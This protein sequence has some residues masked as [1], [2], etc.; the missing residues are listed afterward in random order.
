[1]TN[2]TSIPK[3][4]VNIQ[5]PINAALVDITK[6]SKRYIMQVVASHSK[7]YIYMPVLP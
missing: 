7:P 2:S 1:M 3:A 4:M 5:A 6:E